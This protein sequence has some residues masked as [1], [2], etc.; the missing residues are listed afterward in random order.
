MRGAD[1]K[2]EEERVQRRSLTADSED[3]LIEVGLMFTCSAGSTG[4][5]WY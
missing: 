2:P 4:Q 1:F 5:G 3:V